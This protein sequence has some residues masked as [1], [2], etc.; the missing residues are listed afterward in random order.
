MDTDYEAPFSSQ[1][2]ELVWVLPDGAVWLEE[3]LSPDYDQ[4]SGA[5]SFPDAP[6]ESELRLSF[7]SWQRFLFAATFLAGILFAA[8]LWRLTANASFLPG[9]SLPSAA[10]DAA[11]DESL[12]KGQPVDGEAK[13][14]LL[15][16]PQSALAAGY[17]PLSDRFPPGILRWCEPIRAYA[18]KRGLPP[19]L[20]AA[21]ILQESGGNPSAFSSS[22]AV[23]LMQVMP[24]DGPAASF[25][26]INGPCFASRPSTRELK[27]PDF[28]IAYGTKMLASLLGRH[29]DLREALRSYGPEDVGY[30]YAD[31]VLGIYQ[32]L[33]DHP[34]VN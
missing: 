1:E 6:F 27:D 24:S 9:L 10:G 11:Q 3:E 20:V 2:E 13:D 18:G 21:L 19:D 23:G 7:N 5:Y 28:N 15:F 25:M 30:Y 4:S 16:P 12:N 29:G 33:G 17:C 32:R 31:K 22:G 14:P 34:P 26:C 8:G